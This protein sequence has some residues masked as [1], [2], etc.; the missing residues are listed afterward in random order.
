[1]K[2]SRRTEEERKNIGGRCKNYLLSRE[3]VFWLGRAGRP[4]Q[5]KRSGVLDGKKSGSRE[6]A[7]LFGWCLQ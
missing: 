3:L 1:M 2:A 7:A 4:F 5:G 6:D